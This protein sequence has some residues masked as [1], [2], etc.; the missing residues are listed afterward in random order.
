MATDEIQQV[1]GA[2]DQKVHK[3][4]RSIQDTPINLNRI[5]SAMH[6]VSVLKEELAGIE[7]TEVEVEAMMQHVSALEEILRGAKKPVRCFTDL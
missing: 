1:A 3:R 5:R 7:E 6:R 2:G 4:K